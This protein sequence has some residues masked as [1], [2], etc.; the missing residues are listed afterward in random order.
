MAM[1]LI[2]IALGGCLGQT[3][4][5]PPPA[6]PSLTIPVRDYPPERQQRLAGEIAAAPTG[7]VWPEVVGDY[8][9]LRRAACAVTPRQPACR[10]ICAADGNRHS[11]CVRVN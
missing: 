8:S 6:A 3:V 7:A 2:S 1:L 9:T 10:Q 5:A 11:F 4:S